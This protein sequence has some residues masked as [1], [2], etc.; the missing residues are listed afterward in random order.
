M[1]ELARLK[2]EREEL[3]RKIKMLE[4]WPKYYGPVRVAMANT[5]RFNIDP[6]QD[7]LCISIKTKDQKSHRNVAVLRF[8]GEADADGIQYIESIVKGLND[9][10]DEYEG[11]NKEG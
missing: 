7:V 11:T 4:S 8:N 2:A 1:N 3:D 9:F 10:L 5:S 6:E